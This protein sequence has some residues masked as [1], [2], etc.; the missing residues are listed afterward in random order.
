MTQ[1][2]IREVTIRP[3]RL[4][5]AEAELSVEMR[6][7]F[8]KPTTELRGRLMGP[9]CRYSKTIEVAYPVRMTSRSESGPPILHARVVI[10]EPSW[11]DTESPFTYQGPIELWED[12]R[13]VE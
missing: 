5:P 8:P 13:R 11:W 6:F 10:P 1:T 2:R 12:A 7:A 4:T 3:T 9:S